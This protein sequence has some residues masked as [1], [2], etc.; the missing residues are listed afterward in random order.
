MKIKE[1]I[2][3]SLSLSMSRYFF[4]FLLTCR[5]PS[6]KKWEYRVMTRC[7]FG[8]IYP[9]LWGNRNTIKQDEKNQSTVN[10]FLKMYL[11]LLILNTL[12]LNKI[13][14]IL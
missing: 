13:L 14:I 9:K 5:R 4:F 10:Y 2:L 8:L 11:F 7:P 6:E 3:I 1:V 12:S